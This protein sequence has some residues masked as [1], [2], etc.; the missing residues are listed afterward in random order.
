MGPVRAWRA[1]G[2]IDLGPPQQQA[3]LAVLL[4]R[5]GHPVALS[6]M[7][8]VLWRDDPP[9]S[10]LNVVHRSV[11]RLRRLLEPGLPL[12]AAGRWLPS[13][14]GGYRFSLGD[15]SEQA[16]DFIDLLQF[17]E[18]CRQGWRAQSAEHAVELLLEAVHLR[19]GPCA[20]GTDPQVRA[21]PLFGAVDREYRAAVADLADTALRC[22]AGERVLS[23]NSRR[24][25]DEE[26][27]RCLERALEMFT[28]LGDTVEQAHVRL[29]LGSVL[30]RTPGQERE[31]LRHE[32]EA[33]RLY[34]AA[35]RRI[36]EAWA[37]NNPGFLVAQAFGEPTWNMAVGRNNWQRAYTRSRR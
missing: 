23:V 2:E 10:A 28:K 4:V 37:L 18:L 5:A 25:R 34:H 12:R 6:E 29:V 17:R 35:G 13:A 36:G 32:E 9:A 27:R 16:D 14:S 26:A 19:Q 8:D 15:E 20:A 11:G 24:G 3:V 21:H 22:G 30:L 1:G 7:V 31:G 33:V